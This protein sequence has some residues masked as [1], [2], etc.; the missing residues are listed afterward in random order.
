[1]LNGF[2]SADIPSLKEV[3]PAVNV[4]KR[5]KITAA[6]L[7]NLSKLLPDGKILTKLQLGAT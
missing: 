6:S 3:L 5:Q 4:T 2:P 1:M 7:D